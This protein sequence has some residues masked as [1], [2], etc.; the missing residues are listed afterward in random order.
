M[1]DTTPFYAEMGGQVADKGDVYDLDGQVVAHVTD[2]QHAPNGQNLHTLDVLVPLKKGTTYE[3]K[4]DQVFHS[5]VEKN[6][7]ATH[8]LDKALREVFGEHTQQA[9]SLV[10]GDYLRFDFT[11]FGQVNAADLA[12]AEAIVNQKIFAELPVT[13]VE[14]DIESA[15]KM[16]AIALFSEKYG[17]VV[18]VV[19]A[20]DFVTEFCGGHHVKNTN[21]IGLFK[22]T[23]ESG[24]GAGVRRIEAVT[25]GA[26]YKYLNDHNN[27][28]NTVAADLKVTQIDDVEPK[29]QALQAQVKELQQKQAA[30][31]GKLAGQQAG[32][33]FDHVATAGNYSLISGTVQVSKMDQLRALADTWR[34][35]ALSDVLV[36]GAEVNGKA[37]LIVAVS[38]DKQKQV[39][40]GDL[41]K[42]ISPK[43]N[44][45]GGGR[46]NLAQA[47][48]KNPAGLPDA[49][50]AA[51]DWLTEQD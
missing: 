43:I 46:P 21:E 49:M 9:G 45:G 30:L 16:G 26:A 20:G 5:K 2:V 40:A 8:L 6:H 29:V 25:S 11:H 33:V 50:T 3:L 35:K 48:G 7:T 1:F 51:N 28:L 39:K 44:G 36:L 31:E 42:A 41:I 47:G 14:T 23:S 12:K 22:I 19:S 13:T 4:I 38:A 37:N 27:I 17:K 24:V 32:A 34:E 18:R 15:K 10:E